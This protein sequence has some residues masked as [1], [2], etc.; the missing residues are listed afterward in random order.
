M[1]NIS[2]K[3][4]IQCF[5]IAVISVFMLLF[6]VF[7][8]PCFNGGCALMFLSIFL[9]FSSLVV[10][11]VVFYPMARAYDAVINDTELLA[12]WIYDPD[13]YNQIADREF[14]EYKE[15]NTAFLIIIDGM[16]LICA[17]IFFL[18]VPDGGFE[19]GLFMLGFAVLLF[20]VAKL[21]PG[22]YRARKLKMPAEAWIS[23]EGLIYE[24]SVYPY[25]GFMY[26]CKGISYRGG[27]EPVL[28]FEFFQVTGAGID[29]PFEIIVPVPTGEKEKAKRIAEILIFR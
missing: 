29:D 4:I 25:S 28:V 27:K 18:F 22:Y 19:T 11:V 16:I 2:K 21:T 17:I 8:I 5:I 15:R 20:I 6:G 13:W 10:A 9:F 24:G 1:E 26:G 12:H 23:R 7:I 3:R 14:K